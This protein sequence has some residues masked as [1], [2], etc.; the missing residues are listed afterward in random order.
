MV[1]LTMNDTPTEQI[2]SKVAQTFTVKDT[3]GRTFVLKKP[4]I[5]AQYRI[6]EVAGD[7]ASNEV[8]MRMVLPLIFVVEFDGEPIT[9]PVNKLQLEALIERLGYEGTDAVLSGVVA[10]FGKAPDPE[11]DKAAVKK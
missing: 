5:L 6:V 7:S 1:T 11:A 9:Q 8:Y 10:N 2:L 3:L 4:G